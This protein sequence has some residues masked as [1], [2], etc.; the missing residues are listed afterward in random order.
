MYPNTSLIYQTR[1]AL[2]SLQGFCVS[3]MYSIYTLTWF[4]P[5]YIICIKIYGL[6]FL[7]HTH[8][9]VSKHLAVSQTYAGEMKSVRMKIS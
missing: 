4:V 6:Y 8:I 7:F 9:L 3:F 1:I 5:L 2:C